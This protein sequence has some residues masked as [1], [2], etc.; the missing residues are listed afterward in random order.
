MC[1]CVCVCV[2]VRVCVCVDRLGQPRFEV[3]L[4]ECARHERVVHRA[5]V[6]EAGAA[7]AERGAGRRKHDVLDV[8]E[9]RV[10]ASRVRMPQRGEAV[11][12]RVFRAPRVRT[13]GY[14]CCEYGECCE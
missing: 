12:C 11:S 4:A 14:E 1:A 6:A 5:V 2:C 13:R 8:V 9:A 10:P 7:R 3:C